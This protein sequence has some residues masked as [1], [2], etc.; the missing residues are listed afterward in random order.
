MKKLPT[1]SPLSGLPRPDA[2]SCEGYRCAARGYLEVGLDGKYPQM[3]SELLGLHG[4]R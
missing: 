1:A 3:R 2:R 4:R